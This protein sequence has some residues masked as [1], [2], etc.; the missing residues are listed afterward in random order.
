M[1]AVRLFSVEAGQHLA[2][3]RIVQQVVGDRAEEI[4]AAQELHA[5]GEMQRGLAGG[6]GVVVA[7]AR[8]VE[9]VARGHGDLHLHLS[10]R[11]QGVFIGKA[12]RSVAVDI[13]G[14]IELPFVDVPHLLA[15]DLQHEDVVK[16]EMGGET[17]MPAPGAVDVADRLA[18]QPALQRRSDCG[19][20]ERKRFHEIERDRGAAADQRL[21][22][23][24]I[25]LL[26]GRAVPGLLGDA[27][28]RRANHLSVQ[29]DFQR[30]RRPERRHVEKGGS[31]VP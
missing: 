4:T 24:G 29:H 15:V 9:D 14:L 17:L 23:G 31:L 25:G 8:Y 16:I 28:V 26:Y 21:H 13:R 19:N 6:K 18:V 2:K 7:P 22:P 30:R 27:V 5:E 1:H 10:P 3:E 12:V 11:F 20:F